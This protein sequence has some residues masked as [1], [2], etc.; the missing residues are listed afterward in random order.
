MLV[1]AATTLG[2]SQQVKFGV[3]GGVNVTDLNG[4]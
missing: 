4:A 3:K 1:A 2:F